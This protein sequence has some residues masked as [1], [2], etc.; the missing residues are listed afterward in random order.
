MH[1]SLVI[2]SLLVV[3]SC[4]SGYRVSEWLNVDAQ[5]LIS[6][7]ALY[8]S[9]WEKGMCVAWDK[10]Y[11]VQQGGWMTSPVPLC[12]KGDIVLHS[13]PWWGEPGANFNDVWVWDEYWKRYG[14]RKYGIM[15]GPDKFK[16]Y[17]RE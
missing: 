6:L 2:L 10:V 4:A 13:H 5:T 7:N 15:F 12:E 17:E 1:R 8:D 16:V 3:T 11:N 9:W 14:N